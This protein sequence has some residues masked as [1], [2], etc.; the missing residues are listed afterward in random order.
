MKDNFRIF[1]NG[2]CEWGDWE[3]NSYYDDPKKRSGACAYFDAW[4]S[5]SAIQFRVWHIKEDL[6]IE[7]KGEGFKII[8]RQCVYHQDEFEGKDISSYCTTLVF[9]I[10]EPKG[11]AEVYIPSETLN[12]D[13]SSIKWEDGLLYD[14]DNRKAQ[15]EIKAVDH[16]EIK[17]ILTDSERQNF[18]LKD[19]VHKLTK[20]VRK[21]GRDDIEYQLD[22]ARIFGDF[23]V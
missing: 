6:H 23:Q 15:I 9:Q 10:I 5:C 1:R 14:L 2:E 20:I 7:L 13:N 16:Y 12:E 18:A 17:E 3:D 8:E 21:M 11:K 19:R 22:L 4:P